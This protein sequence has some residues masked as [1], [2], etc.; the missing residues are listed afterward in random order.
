MAEHEIVVGSTTKR[1]ILW[2]HSVDLGNPGLHV[3]GY[4]MLMVEQG[5]LRLLQ[6]VGTDT[7]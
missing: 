6:R 2:Q 7:L 5:N 4:V 3:I 1:V